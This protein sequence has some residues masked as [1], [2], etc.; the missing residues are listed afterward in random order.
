MAHKAFPNFEIALLKNLAIETAEQ[1][2]GTELSIYFKNIGLQEI[3]QPKESKWKR[4]LKT[5]QDSQNRKHNSNEVLK[6]IQICYSP[7]NFRD[8]KEEFRT[9]LNKLNELL[10]VAGLTLNEE[11][12]FLL[13]SN[14][15]IFSI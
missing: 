8:K 4:V 12:I 7:V 3:L 6:L 14:N 9:E 11:G 10:K 2:T 13:T 5:W 1:A 15:Q